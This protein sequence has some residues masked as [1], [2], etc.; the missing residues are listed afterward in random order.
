M[1]KNNKKIR[2]KLNYTFLIIFCF[3]FFSTSAS[4]ITKWTAPPQPGGVPTDIDAGILNLTNWVLGFVSMISTL[5]IIWGGIQYLTSTGDTNKA[6]SGKKTITY[7]FI[8]LI[9][10]A[11]SYAIIKVIVITILK[12]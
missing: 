4:A 3:L 6:E 9:I 2:K 7:A 11:L 12:S 1:T 8:G 5:M 10:A